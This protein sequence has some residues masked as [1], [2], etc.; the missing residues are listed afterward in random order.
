[1]CT[2]QTATAGTVA[3]RDER[4]VEWLIMW[5]G[6]RARTGVLVCRRVIDE[7]R[8]TTTGCPGSAPV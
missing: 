3:Q 2:A 7:C 6:S 5:T 1:V 4:R 8:R